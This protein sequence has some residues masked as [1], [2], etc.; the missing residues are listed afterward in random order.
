MTA[1]R[2]PGGILRRV[3]VD[4]G[5]YYEIPPN[6]HGISAGSILLPTEAPI[7]ASGSSLDFVLEQGG[8]EDT[9]VFL[10]GMRRALV[11]VDVLEGVFLSDAG[12]GFRPSWGFQQLMRETELGGWFV[13]PTKEVLRSWTDRVEERMNRGA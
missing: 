7:V 2:A 6:P 9:F 3:F 8:D 4:P 12:P 13:V 11:G 5:Q 10:F 1:A